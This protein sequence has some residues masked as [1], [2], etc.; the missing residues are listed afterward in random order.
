MRFFL[1]KNGR[2]KKK[3]PGKNELDIEE[4][5]R[6]LAKDVPVT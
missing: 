5:C 6:K 1:P 2:Q 3:N 4:D